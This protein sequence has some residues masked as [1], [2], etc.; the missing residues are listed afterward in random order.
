[1][2]PTRR[3]EIPFPPGPTSHSNH[4]LI[5]NTSTCLRV[6][7]HPP[8]LC[9]MWWCSA[10]P[11]AASMM[12]YRHSSSL[13]VPNSRT[14]LGC[15]AHGKGGVS[16]ACRHDHTGLQRSMLHRVSKSGPG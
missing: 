7:K 11:T 1:M 8:G 2:T 13:S 5:I 6:S 12:K 10:P 16:R 9:R 4:Y 15:C 3:V 14:M